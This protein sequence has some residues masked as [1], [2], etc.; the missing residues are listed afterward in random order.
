MGCSSWPFVSDHE[1]A[2]ANH[3]EVDALDSWRVPGPRGEGRDPLSPV[4][5]GQRLGRQSY[6]FLHAINSDRETF[7]YSTDHPAGGRE[8]RDLNRNLVIDPPD[9]IDPFLG[10]VVPREDVT[11]SSLSDSSTNTLGE[12]LD[13]N[14]IL[15]APERD[16]IPNGIVDGPNDLTV[17]R[18][19]TWNGGTLEGGGGLNVG[20]NGTF[21]LVNGT[22]NQ[23][24]V[25][26][27]GMATWT[28]GG[29]FARG[30]SYA[31]NG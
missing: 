16:I 20:S 17:N 10:F 15:N 19:F 31:G 24:A 12:D 30:G 4:S 9:A 23:R 26:N 6:S 28:G 11:F 2:P 8:V 7:L 27:A 13:G 5:R 22:L 18:A 29:V 14:V 25:S 1:P 3:Q 21:N